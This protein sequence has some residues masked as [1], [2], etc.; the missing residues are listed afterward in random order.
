VSTRPAK[1]CAGE[2][3]VMARGGV[4]VSV[5]AGVGAFV[6]GHYGRGSLWEKAFVPSVYCR[7]ALF[8]APSCLSLCKI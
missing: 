3:G 6:W 8:G 2:A 5:C 4:C 1:G 7:Q